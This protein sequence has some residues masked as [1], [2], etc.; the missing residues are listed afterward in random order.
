MSCVWG[1]M[2]EQQQQQAGQNNR[3]PSLNMSA[4]TSGKDLFR[5]SARVSWRLRDACERRGRDGDH[6]AVESLRRN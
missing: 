3:P 1:V 4:T 6:V 5:G 2:A